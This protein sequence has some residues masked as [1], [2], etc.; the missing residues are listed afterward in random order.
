MIGITTWIGIRKYPM[1]PVMTL[2]TFLQAPETR[3]PVN[4][5]YRW[6]RGFLQRVVSGQTIRIKGKKATIDLYQPSIRL[7]KLLLDPRQHLTRGSA[8]HLLPSPMAPLPTKISGQTL[9][10]TPFGR[11]AMILKMGLGRSLDH[12]EMRDLTNDDATVFGGHT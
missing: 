1:D 9:G 5:A 2:I 11:I 8:P 4:M 12:C 10:F 7:F 6:D 3:L